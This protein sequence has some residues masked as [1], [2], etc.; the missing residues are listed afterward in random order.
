[1]E[2][3]GNFL[4]ASPPPGNSHHFLYQKQIARARARKSAPENNYQ[5]IITGYSSCPEERVNFVLKPPK[6]YPDAFSECFNESSVEHNQEKMFDVDSFGSINENQLACDYD[7]SQIKKKFELSIYFED[8]AYYLDLPWYEDKI[9]IIPSN[10][11]VALKVLDKTVK[12][13]QSKKLYKEYNNAFYQQERAGIIERI[14]VSP[15]KFS[16]YIWIP[17]RPVIK[18]D[19]QST[20]KIRPVFNCSL[21]TRGTCSL[22]EASYPGINLINDMLKLLLLFRTNKYVLLADIR[23]AFLMIKLNSEKDKNRFCFF[24]KEGDKIIC[25]RYSTLIFRFNASPFIFLYVL[26]HH[27]QQ[28]PGDPCTQMLK[29]NFYM[30]NLSKTGNSSEELHCLYQE[31][32]NRLWKGGFDLSS[33]NSNCE[34]LKKQ[35][36]DNRIVQHASNV[37]KV[38]GYKYNPK[39]DTLQISNMEVNQK[40]KTKRGLLSQTARV[41]DPLSFCVPVTVR[42]KILLRELLSRK[43]HWDDVIPVQLQELWTILARDL[44]GLSDLK[45]PRQKP[46]IR[47]AH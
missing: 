19:E 8:N 10:Y 47:T 29:N 13:L 7:K 26:K 46:S 17:Y 39:R 36:K 35:M 16:E 40:V 31:A 32:I 1:M 24:L 38:L 11:Q 15:G 37:E 20:T 27:A 9:K 44:V 4:Q 34:Q 41:F 6:T 3:P 45:F 14:E 2:K 23:K 33:C 43:L 28:F 21:K 22:N 25:F 30:D 5:T 18:M 42:A 12:Y